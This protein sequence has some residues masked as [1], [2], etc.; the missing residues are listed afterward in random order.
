MLHVFLVTLCYGAKLGLERP[1]Y[2]HANFVH[3]G[4]LDCQDKKRQNTAS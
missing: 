2:S 4:Y 1:Q 3:V